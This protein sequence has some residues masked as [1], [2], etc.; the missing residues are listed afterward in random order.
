FNEV[1][2]GSRTIEDADGWSR[3]SEHLPDRR[4][5]GKFGSSLRDLLIEFG[6]PELSLFHPI[7]PP[8]LLK[9]FH[10]V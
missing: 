8:G 9:R 10:K 5:S 3:I 1:A 7:S 2:R 4:I 6:R